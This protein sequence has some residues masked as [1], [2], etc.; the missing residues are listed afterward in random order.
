MLAA[1]YVLAKM[2]LLAGRSA[3]W[4][5]T[6]SVAPGRERVEIPK[7]DGDP[8]PPLFFG[9]KPSGRRDTVTM[10]TLPVCLALRRYP[11]SVRHFRS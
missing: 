1:R 8:R 10:S 7:D 6:A 2:M 5:V 3:L 4:H 9:L 11:R